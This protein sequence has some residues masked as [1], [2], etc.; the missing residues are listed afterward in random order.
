MGNPDSVQQF[1]SDIVELYNTVR[2]QDVIYQRDTGD[3][4]HPV[5]A[6]EDLTQA[7]QAVFMFAAMRA[8]EHLH[9]HVLEGMV[10]RR[11]GHQNGGVR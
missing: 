9:V 7:E 1:T 10:C 2:K 4:S 8:F 5:P 3:T 11:L 6:W